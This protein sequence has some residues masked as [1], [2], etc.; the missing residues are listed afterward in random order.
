VHITRPGST[1]AW[2]EHGVKHHLA[3]FRS[4]Q[5]IRVDDLEV[6]DM[7]RT[8]ADIAREHGEPY[9]E[10]AC[11]AAMRHGVTRA[12]LEAACEP[13]KSWQHIRRVRRAVEFANPGAQNLAETLGRL[14]V[15]EL[16]LTGEMETQFPARVGTEGRVAWGDIRVGPH[17]FEIDGHLKL[18]APAE[19]GVAEAPPH[20]V[21]WAEK[22]R[23]RDLWREGLGASHIVWQDFWPPHRATALKRLRAEYDHTV[24]HFGEVL[25]ERL[26]RQAREI[27]GQRGA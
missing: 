2:T 1:N 22:K 16:G 9:G 21:V 15:A 20:E 18:I 8:A 13:M 7:A 14:L 4:E 23:D 5:V 3:A 10:I 26:L 25:P 19:G 27:R 24:A 12:Q 17:L 6:L 11:D